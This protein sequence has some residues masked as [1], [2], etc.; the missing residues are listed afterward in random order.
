M[1]CLRSGG[2]CSDQTYQSRYGDSGDERAARNQGCSSEDVVHHQVDDHPQ[3]TALGLV[4]Q[5]GEVAQRADVGMH[6]VEVGDVVPVIPTRRRM[7]G[8]E[9]AGR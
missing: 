2:S 6:T 3:A 8:I 9:P 4:D 7:D 5:F 1:P